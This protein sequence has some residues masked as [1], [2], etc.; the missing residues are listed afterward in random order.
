MTALGIFVMVAGVVLVAAYAIASYWGGMFLPSQV[1]AQWH[2]RGLPLVMHGGMWG[3][4]LLLPYI[5]GAVAA[6]FGDQWE[7]PHVRW[8]L[9]IGFIVTLGNHINLCVNQRIPDPFGWQEEWWSWA[10]FFHFLYMWGA[11]AI[12]ILFVFFTSGAEVAVVVLM[13]AL[14]GLHL[15]FGIH[16]PLG[17]LN[18]Y[19]R[20]EWSPEFLRPDSIAFA[21]GLWMVVSALAWIPGGWRAATLAALIGVGCMIM[22]L[23]VYTD[24]EPAPQ[25]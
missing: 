2:Q 11:T 10:I 3:D 5:L 9:L 17:M 7:V 20:F 24:T 16:M 25:T 19:A 23:V 13:A 12:I 4:L 14:V 21:A 6:R 8:A 1:I 15:M 22:I 18:R